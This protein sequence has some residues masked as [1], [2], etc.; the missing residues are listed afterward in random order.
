MP[1]VKLGRRLLLRLL[2]PG[3][4][5]QSLLDRQLKIGRRVWAAAEV[6]C[7][8]D[9]CARS[10]GPSRIGNDDVGRKFKLDG[11]EIDSKSRDAIEIDKWRIFGP[12]RCGANGWQFGGLG[13]LGHGYL[14]RLCESHHA[15]AEGSVQSS[16]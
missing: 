15:T 4:H 5:L 1:S 2:R 9:V 14:P 6:R 8:R 10:G 3:Q 7:H 12:Q 13:R 16:I 11:A